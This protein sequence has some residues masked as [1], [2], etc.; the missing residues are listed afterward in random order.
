M[1][2]WIQ[3]VTIV[4]TLLIL[5]QFTFKAFAQTGT[6]KLAFVSDR[7]STPNIFVMNADGSTVTNVTNSKAQQED[8]PAWSPDGTTLV[9]T[10]D[11]SEDQ[12]NGDSWDLFTVGLD[13]I[14]AKPLTTGKQFAGNARWS[15]NGKQIAYE[16]GSSSISV[17][18][19]NADG[20]GDRPLLDPTITSAINDIRSADW[21]PDGTHLVFAAL[22]GSGNDNL[23]TV[24]AT[25]GEP[26]SVTKSAGVKQKVVLSPDGKRITYIARLTG[27]EDWEIWI[28]NA[29]GSNATQVTDN[30]ASDREMVWS[31]DSTRIAFTTSRDGNGEIYVMN[32][33]GSNQTNLT[34][35]DAAEGFPAW[36]PDGKQIA[37]TSTRDGNSEI[38]VMNADGSNPINLT[39]NP[40]SDYESVWQPVSSGIAPIG[41]SAV[42]VSPA[43]TETSLATEATPSATEGST[44]SAPTTVATPEST[45]APVTCIVTARSSANLRTGPG[46]SFGRS[47]SLAGGTPVEADG[48]ATA[49]DG[50]T[51]YRLVRGGWVRG[52]LVNVAVDCDTLT[53][54]AS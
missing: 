4:V 52:D 54:V 17:N 9:F 26:Q 16:T 44:V 13:G 6:G 24:E 29:D 12:A 35:T 40:A 2:R 53:T 33:D 45:L 10:R 43:A 27:N 46:T 5:G 21:S 39:N 3:V 11:V 8:E 31:P 34:R 28:A 23:W 49:A 36:S 19:I 1:K 48:Q 50:F 14:E 42:S 18:L 25:G 51:W 37:F 41:S 38:Y 22:F 7:D 15:P 47:G 30:S 20:S 32:A